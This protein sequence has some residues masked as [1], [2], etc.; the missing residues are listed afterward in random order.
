[1]KG[2]AFTGFGLLSWVGSRGTTGH[3]FKLCQGRFGM[4]IKENFLTERMVQA[5]EQADQRS[6]GIIIHRTVQNM[7]RT[8]FNGGPGSAGLMIGPWNLRCLLQPS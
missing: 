1:M 4:V 6:G 3:G 2:Q 5:L 7:L 8:W